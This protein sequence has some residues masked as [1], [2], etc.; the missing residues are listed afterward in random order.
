[1]SLKTIKN[2]IKSVKKIRQVTRAMEAV[3]A[4]K[5]RKSQQKAFAARPYAE[6]ALSILSRVSGSKEIAS[7]PLFTLRP[8]INKTLLVVVT[9]DRG[10]AG[11]LNSTL[12]R[13]VGKLMTLERLTRQ[14][15]EVIAIG[16]KGREHFERRGFRVQNHFERWGEGVDIDS[17]SQIVASI[18]SGYNAGAFDRAFIVYTNFLSTFKQEAVVRQFLPIS[19]AALTAVV[20]GIAPVAGTYAGGAK[21]SISDSVEYVLEPSIS[22]IV[23]ALVPRLL[24]IELYHAVLESNA[25][26]HSA[27]MVAMKMASGR[28]RDLTKELTLE[29]NKARQGAITS[30]IS[31]LVGGLEAMR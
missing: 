24:S 10:L 12:F 29:F 14:T 20:A 4:V 5:M 11:S 27:R 15:A 21:A 23:D 1:M 30:E 6:S 9:A 3:S 25:S 8:Q 28:A 13:E 2:K 18:L 26:E 31:E 16:R 22:A 19:I 7:H 17:P